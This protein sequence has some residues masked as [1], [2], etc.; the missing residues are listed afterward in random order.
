MFTAIRGGG[1]YQPHG[2]RVICDV[3]ACQVRSGNLQNGKKRGAALS[4]DD[5]TAT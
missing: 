5:K 4:R 3:L 1:D 2:T